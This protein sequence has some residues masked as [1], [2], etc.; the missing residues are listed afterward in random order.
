MLPVALGIKEC[1]PDGVEPEDIPC[2]VISTWEYTPPC[3]SYQA[4]VYNTSGI[5]IVNFTFIDYGDSG[6]C[7]FIW[8]ITSVDSYIGTV[9]NGDTFN[10]IVKVDNMQIGLVLGIGILIATMLWIAFKLEEEH[11]IIKISMIFFSIILMGII[12]TVFIIDTTSAILH[13]LIMGF[14]VVFW[15]YVAGYLIYWILKK[16]GVIVSG[17]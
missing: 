4:T 10:I 6:R 17:K 2:Q 13:K 3:N 16:M 1:L 8:N 15:L 12:P 7:Y 9:E 11:G 5:N 14:T